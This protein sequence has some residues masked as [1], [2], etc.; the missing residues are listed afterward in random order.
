[1][2]FYRLKSG[3]FVMKIKIIEFIFVFITSI[4]HHFIGFNLKM[5]NDMSGDK[6]LFN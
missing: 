4:T 5:M 2:G 1:M 3:D 6:L